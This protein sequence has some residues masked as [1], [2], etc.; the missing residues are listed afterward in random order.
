[1]TSDVREVW[2]GTPRRSRRGAAVAAVSAA[3]LL[4]SCGGNAPGV[5]ATVAGDRITDE[6]VDEFAQVLCSL[7]G[8]PGAEADTPTRAARLNSLRILVANELAADIADLEDVDKSGVALTV[9]SINAG[10]ET[11]PEG[12]RDTFD[13]VVRE[14]AVAEQAI[15]QLGEESLR[16]SGQGGDGAI[17]EEA[18]R[19]EGARLRSEYAAEAD[20]D[21]DPRFGTVEDGVI[22]PADGSLS[23]PVSE[24]A[25]QGAVEQV[26]DSFVS[27][28]PA[29]QKCG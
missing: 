21:V 6:R 13:E 12:V 3:L 26:E 28:L 1:V 8:Q 20:I 5:A 29:T 14:F 25:R 11:V 18:A 15:L 2:R 27:A 19:A 10:R 17:N 7:G 4:S 9:E 22:G 16:D 24:L 23:V